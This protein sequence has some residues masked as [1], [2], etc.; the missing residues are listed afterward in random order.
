MVLALVGHKSVQRTVINIVNSRITKYPLSLIGTFT[1]SIVSYH[2]VVHSTAN[3]QLVLVTVGESNWIRCK[4][5]RSRGLCEI[6]A[7]QYL[8]QR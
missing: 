3:T 8:S 5:K 6:G 4:T 1:L 2:L 7:R